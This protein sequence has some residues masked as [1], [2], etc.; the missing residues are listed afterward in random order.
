M[1]SFPSLFVS[2]GAPTLT[3]EDVPAR[4]FLATLGATLGRPDAIVAVS[5]HHVARGVAVSAA[6]KLDTVHDFYGFPAPLYELRYDAPGEPSLAREVA[7]RLNAA[8]LAAATVDAPGIDHGAWVP[9]SLMYPGA[10]VPVVPVSLDATMDERRHVAIGR[11]L[12]PLRERGILVMASG[13]FTHNLREFGRWPRDAEAAGYVVEFRRWM[14]EAMSAGDEP[15]LIDW[16]RLA[17][18][19][20]R[21]HPTPEHL[22]PLFVAWGAGGEGASMR[23]LHDSVS[24]G[25]LAM[26][27]FT[28]DRTG[29]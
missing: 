18:H 1:T 4:A 24:Y 14:V 15:S 3:M 11:A 8:G 6:P 26:D 25:M 7:D 17:P 5:A 21:A 10:D 28:F 13:G 12:A 23:Q 19:A 9:L 16:R 29:A 27:A 22:M 20:L 2:H